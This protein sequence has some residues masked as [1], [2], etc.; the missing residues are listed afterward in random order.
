MI[1][2]IAR[3]LQRPRRPNP[4]GLGAHLLSDI[5]LNQVT[6]QFAA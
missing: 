2:W 1:M 5:G 6:A 3:A 4:D